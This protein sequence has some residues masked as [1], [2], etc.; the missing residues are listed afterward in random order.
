MIPYRK[1]LYTLFLAYGNKN[2][3]KD[4]QKYY[5]PTFH[6]DIA[7]NDFLNKIQADFSTCLYMEFSDEQFNNYAKQLDIEFCFVFRH[8]K[9]PGRI[10]DDPLLKRHVECCLIHNIDYDIIIS[11]IKQIYHIDII[12]NEIIIFKS[13]FFNLDEISNSNS[14][15]RYIETLPIEEQNFKAKCRANGINYTR[16]A[17]GCQ[18]SLN[19]MD[20]TKEMLVEGFFKYKESAKSK[21][22]IDIENA[23]KWGGLVTKLIDRQ[24]KLEDKKPSDDALD[25]LEQLCLFENKEDDPRMAGELKDNTKPNT[26]SS[27][28][29]NIASLEDE[30][31]N[32]EL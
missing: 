13:L 6:I 23:M 21:N 17:L 12:I 29:S 27:I 20:I 19:A 26:I 2:I 8:L 15:A 31:I 11:D 24:I 18:I 28:I 9:L 4:L 3:E 5:L 30:Q 14:W 32:L 7:Y 16:W 22:Q 25:N 1:Y 10:V